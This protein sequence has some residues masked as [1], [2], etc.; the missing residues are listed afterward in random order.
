VIPN[1]FVCK[2][3]CE[4]QEGTIVWKEI[5]NVITIF[6]IEEAVESAEIY[7]KPGSPPMTRDGIQFFYSCYAYFT[8]LFLLIL[9]RHD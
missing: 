9:K 1:L 7:A 6:Y 4:W 8:A 3:D 2:R 5:R